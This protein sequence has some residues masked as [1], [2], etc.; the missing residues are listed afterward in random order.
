MGR[1]YCRIHISERR[2]CVEGYSC[3]VQ[4][5][6][7]LIHNSTLMVLLAISYYWD[8]LFVL[9]SSACH[10][11]HRIAYLTISALLFYASEH[12][13]RAWCQRVFD[14][15]FHFC[16]RCLYFRYASALCHL[17]ECHL[18]P[19]RFRRVGWISAAGASGSPPESGV[20]FHLNLPL[21]LRGWLLESLRS[22]FLS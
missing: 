1:F 16:C 6:S 12:S 22:F 7:T 21:W 8:E 11:Q 10:K 19:C 2:K 9:N 3:I 4:W 18:W 20:G 5:C 14:G 15:Q 17:H 13:S